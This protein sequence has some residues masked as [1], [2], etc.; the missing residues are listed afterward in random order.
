MNRLS[1]L[2]QRGI[3]LIVLLTVSMGAYSATINF[4]GQLV[5]LEN[6]GGIYT[7]TPEGTLMVGSIDD[8]TFEGQIS[9]GTTVTTFDCC[10]VAGGLEITNNGELSVDEAT[11]LNALAGSPLFSGGMLVDGVDIEGDA[12][13][14]GGGRIEVGV[15]YLFDANT[16]SNED[17]SNYPFDSNDVLLALF[18]I[19][20]EDGIGN[21]IYSAVGRIEVVPL[22]AAAGLFGVSMGMLG[23]VRR[24]R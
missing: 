23:F 4:S 6:T 2:I 7:S 9:D 8:V 14:V 16:F 12:E 15:S 22:P 17:V 18:F 11:A 24:R 13:T 19:L 5:E 3:C 20:E 1:F 21:D 10:I